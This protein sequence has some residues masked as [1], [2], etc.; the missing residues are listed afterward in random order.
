MWLRY[1]SAMASSG[2]SRGLGMQWLWYKKLPLRTRC[3]GGAAQL[4]ILLGSWVKGGVEAQGPKL[5][6]CC[7]VEAGE[8]LHV[9][10]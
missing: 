5:T 3:G 10:N 7:G 6:L 4:R 2:D 1:P 8:D 9:I